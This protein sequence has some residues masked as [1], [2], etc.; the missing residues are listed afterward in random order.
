MLRRRAA[1]LAASL[2]G[3]DLILTQSL[4]TRLHRRVIF[5]DHRQRI[6]NR[7]DA[8]AAME[9]LTHGPLL[10][11]LAELSSRP[12]VDIE[13]NESAADLLAWRRSLARGLVPEDKLSFPPE[14][15]MTSWKAALLELDMPRFTRRHPALLDMCLQNMLDL[16]KAYEE[17]RVQIEAEQQSSASDFDNGEAEADDG[18]TGGGSGGDGGG[19]APTG[20]GDDE[21]ETDGGNIQASGSSAASETANDGSSGSQ[22]HGQLSQ[23]GGQSATGTDGRSH[24][25]PVLGQLS[26]DDQLQQDGPPSE[27]AEDKSETKQPLENGDKQSN[28]TADDRYDDAD[29]DDDASG[30][31]DPTASVPRW[32]KILKNPGQIRLETDASDRSGDIM[33]RFRHQNR[34]SLDGIA[35]QLLEGFKSKWSSQI[36]ETDRASKLLRELGGDGANLDPTLTDTAGWK[37]LESLKPLLDSDHMRPF[38]DLVRRLGRGGTRG[39]R[40]RALLQHAQPKGSRRVVQSSLVS[41]EISDGAICRSDELSRM[42]PSESMLACSENPALKLLFTARRAERALV[43][44]EYA[45]WI[46]M[47][48]KPRTRMGV[49]PAGKGG[50]LLV[51]LDTSGSMA[52]HREAV[53]KAVALKCISAAKGKKRS[54]YLYAFGGQQQLA[55][56]SVGVDPGEGLEELLGF[57]C[58]SFSA[59]TDIDAP[60][61][62][63]LERLHDESWQD[64]DILLITDGM[65][66]AP[67]IELMDQLELAKANLGLEVH[68][69]LVGPTIASDPFASL[70][71]KVHAVKLERST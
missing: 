59:G 25:E 38:E 32:D 61:A 10:Q 41:E 48:A 70:C 60:L 46:E 34:S 31:T 36:E 56:L 43:T 16:V 12:G 6:S 4:S 17:E 35:N 68:G 64:A 7:T 63:C 55:E 42:L 57:L 22:Q 1:G 24:A 2:A 29:T 28:L 67:S 47:E 62:G 40:R 50:P 30:T 13:F 52:G 69:L 20:E 18:S 44:Y 66:R 26:A 37:H 21:S 11:Q 65:F 8:Y 53:S 19:D 51:C 33:D 23:Q 27:S 49:R 54:C 9:R 5:R 3:S 58:Y 14:P 71:T 45:G 15:F 39:R